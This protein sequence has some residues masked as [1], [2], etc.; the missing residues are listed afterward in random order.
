M[1]LIYNE[2]SEIQKSETYNEANKKVECFIDTFIAAQKKGFNKIRF[3]KY[4]QN[5]HLA[6]GVTLQDWIVTS[7]NVTRKNLLLSIAKH[8]FLRDDMSDTEIE[9]YI[10]HEF[11][12]QDNENYIYGLGCEGLSAAHIYNVPLISLCSNPA[13]MKSKLTLRKTTD[14]KIHSFVDVYNVFSPDCLSKQTVLDFIESIK[15]VKLIE[16]EKKIEEK[17]ISLREDHGKDTLKKFSEKIISSPYVESVINSLPFNPRI[18][19]FIKKTFENGKIELVLHW[20]DRGIGIIIQTTGRNLQET[21][22]I[23]EILRDKYE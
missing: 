16:S 22:A 6:K 20:E 15:E 8:P 17:T 13:W 18:R 4:F 1:E 5:I 21:N 9:N 2:L 14:D 7:R 19:R 23:A 10:N 3:S 12:F 11:F